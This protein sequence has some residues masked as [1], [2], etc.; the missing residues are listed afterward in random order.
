MDHFLL[1]VVIPLYNEEDTVMELY[2]LIKEQFSQNEISGEIIFVND[3][4]TDMSREKVN[5]LCHNDEDCRLISFRANCGKAAA[6]SVGFRA[7]KGKYVITMDADLQ[8]DPIEI[9]RFLEALQ[10]YD[11][12]SGWKKNRFDPA[13]KRLPSKL[14][15]ATVRFVTG[16]KLHDMN[17][18]FKGYR[19]EALKELRLY[20]DLHR[21]IPALLARRGFKITEIVVKHH[22]RK[23][24]KSKYGIER[25]LHGLF[26][27]ITVLFITKYMQRPLHLL[28]AVAGGAFVLGLICWILSACAIGFS[29]PAIAFFSTVLPLIGIGLVLERV[30][31]EKN[32]DTNYP[33]AEV[34]NIE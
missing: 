31:Y 5:I 3:G 10:E 2:E 25:Y 6:L 11:I 15:N 33:I 8:D 9:P 4:S 18:G 12:V 13:E 34:K 28:G 14:Y 22:E 20:G 19:R 1:S 32:P 26:D 29:V 7:A 23:S 17:C 30:T 21:Y 16:T 24:G 27:L